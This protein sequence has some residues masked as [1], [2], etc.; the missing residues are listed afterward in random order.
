MDKQTL[1]LLPDLCDKFPSKVN[2]LECQFSH[3]GKQPVFSGQVV[4]VKCFEDNSIVKNLVNT[5]GHGK[6]IVVDGGGSTRCALLGDM[7]AEAAVK[8]GWS[9]LI[10][11]GVIRDVATINTLSIGV[12]ALGTTPIKTEKRGLG[13]LNIPV[14]FAGVTISE[15]NWVY[16]DLNG[17]LISEHELNIGDN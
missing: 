7:L 14:R 4:T 12:K 1:D 10:I 9:G 15:N 17:V 5:P 11:N 3:Y 2:V 6:V 16:A 13:D 8:N